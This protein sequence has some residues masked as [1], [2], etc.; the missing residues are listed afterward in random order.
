MKNKGGRPKIEIDWKILDELCRLQCTQEEIAEYMGISVDSLERIAKREK[1]E[2][3]AEYFNKRRKVGFVSIRRKQYQLAMQGNVTMLI[4]LGKNWLGQV[5]KHEIE[6]FN[7][8]IKLSYNVNS[9]S[10]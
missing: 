4:W 3:F 8:E 5:D 9:E 7:E 2:S 10:N 1:G 6:H